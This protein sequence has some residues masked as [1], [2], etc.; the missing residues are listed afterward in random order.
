MWIAQIW[1]PGLTRVPKLASLPPTTEAFTE[2]I[3]RA[4]LQTFLWNSALKLDPQKLEPTDYGWVKEQNMK[5]LQPSR[6]P[7]FLLE[8][9]KID[10]Y[11][12]SSEPL[13]EEADSFDYWLTNRGSYPM[14][15]SMAINMLS[16][17]GSSMPPDIPL[18]PS[19][20]LQMM[21][22]TC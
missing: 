7:K 1:K 17:P 3:K 16:I 13:A 12:D 21:R 8:S 18:A 5:S 10:R 20:I 2:N 22:C 11:F 15:S 19:D 14:L 6:S 4:H 9:W